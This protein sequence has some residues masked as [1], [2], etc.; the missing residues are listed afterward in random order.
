LA[1]DIKKRKID[2]SIICGILLFHRLSITKELFKRWTISMKAAVLVV[3]NLVFLSDSGIWQA[4]KDK[5][6]SG[7]PYGH[8]N[9]I[10]GW[11]CTCSNNALQQM[12]DRIL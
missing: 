8:E 5:M 7:L 1:D 6:K 3:F 10:V 11:S 12:P 2:T 4:S 9:Q